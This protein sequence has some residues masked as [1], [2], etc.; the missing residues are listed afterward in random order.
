MDTMI[1]HARHPLQ[2]SSGLNSAIIIETDK[3]FN[4]WYNKT[5]DL[6]CKFVIKVPKG[7]HLFAVVQSLSF[8]RGDHGCIDYIEVII[9]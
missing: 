4:R 2:L 9:K 1:C 3:R 7:E 8:R 5:N 6:Y